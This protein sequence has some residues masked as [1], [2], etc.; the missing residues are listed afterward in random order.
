VHRNLKPFRARRMDWREYEKL[1]ALV[2]IEAP[3]LPQL[4]P[5][6]RILPLVPTNPPE[7][8][9]IHMPDLKAMR[10]QQHSTFAIRKTPH[11]AQKAL[12]R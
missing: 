9:R 6:P 1:K 5:A 8:V 7:P 12:K 2:Q 4:Q 3:Q 10:R 11:N